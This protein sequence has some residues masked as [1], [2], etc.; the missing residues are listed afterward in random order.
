[1][2]KYVIIYPNNGNDCITLYD[3]YDDAYNNLSTV[4]SDNVHREVIKF[5][6][7]IE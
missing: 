6:D 7:I 2:E 4:E 5:N 1:M 3:S